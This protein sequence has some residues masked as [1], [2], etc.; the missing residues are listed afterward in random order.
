MTSEDSMTPLFFFY[1]NSSLL[2]HLTVLGHVGLTQRPAQ[3]C[4]T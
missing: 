1:W 2:L 4:S 3:L